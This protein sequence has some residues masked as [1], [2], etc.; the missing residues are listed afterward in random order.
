M[1]VRF[2]VSQQNVRSPFYHIIDLSH[3]HL[4][5]CTALKGFKAKYGNCIVP[6]EYGSLGRFVRNSRALYKERH[7]TLTEDRRQMLDEVRG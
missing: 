3:L 1:K 7:Q 5:L 4:L 6:S 2:I